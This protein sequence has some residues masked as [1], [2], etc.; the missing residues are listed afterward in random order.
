MSK[1]RMKGILGIGHHGFKDQPAPPAETVSRGWH[2]NT[3]ILGSADIA[4]T[5]TS[6]LA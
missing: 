2:R 6:G 5:L 1:R 3:T 4:P